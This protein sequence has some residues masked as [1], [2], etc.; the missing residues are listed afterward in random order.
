MNVAHLGLG[1]HHRAC[2]S[3]C[4]P[5][6]CSS[7][8]AGRTSRR[9]REC[10][11]RDRVL[12]RPG[13][14]LRRRRPGRRRR[15]QYAGEFYAG[16]LTEYSLSIDNLFVFVI[17]MAR[18]AVPR[19]LPAEGA[20]GRHHPGAGHARDL[21]RRSARRRSSS[22]SWV[23]YLFGAFLVY[24]A[25]KLATQG[26]SDEDDFK[27]NRLLRLGRAAVLPID[28]GLRTAS[29]SSPGSDGKRVITPMLDRHHRAR[30]DRPAVR[31]GLDPGDLRA[32]RGAVP[33]LHRQRVRAD[34]PAPAVLPARRPA[35]AAGLPEPRPGGDARLHRRQAG[36]GGAARERAA[37]HQR[38][39][40]RHRVPEIPIW[41]SLAVII[42]HSCGH[43]RRQPAEG[44]AGSDGGLAVRLCAAWTPAGGPSPSP[45]C[46][47]ASS[48]A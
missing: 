20:A 35:R 44:P 40:A 33:R 47:S 37:V 30:H 4:S 22:F 1:R 42:D 43:H 23:F 14:A 15:P 16:W 10:A 46:S 26:E 34:G 21:H 3:A 28:P 5:S 18:F 6:T 38:R 27:E 2:S 12:R 25:V 8:G 48:S 7:S 41:V 17:I 24:T 13:G 32:H 19:Q 29:S 36:P 9:M 45:G 11:H 39:R 31:A